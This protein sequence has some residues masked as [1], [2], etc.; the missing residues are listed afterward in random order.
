VNGSLAKAGA[1]RTI[2]A[3]DSATLGISATGD[4]YAWTSNP[5][6]FSSGIANPVVS[7]AATTTYYLEVING[8]CSSKDTVTV[9]VASPPIANAG[10]DQSICPGFNAIIGTFAVSGQ[11]YSWTSDPAGFIANS[12][13]PGVRPA[14]TTRY[15]LRVSNGSCA[16]YDTVVITVLPLPVAHA[17]NDT[18]ICTGSSVSIGSAAIAGNTYSWTS[19]PAG[20]ASNAATVVVNPAVPTYYYLAVNDG[21]CIAKDTIHVSLL[22][23]PTAVAGADTAICQGNNIIIGTTA[24]PGFKYAWTSSSGYTSPGAIIMVSPAVTTSYF[25]QVTVGNCSSKDT[26]V[27]QVNPLPVLTL[28]DTLKTI[29]AGTG[30]NIGIP[31]QAGYS[32]N[33]TSVPAGF[34]STVSDPFVSPTVTTTYHLAQTNIGTGCT[35]SGRVTVTVDTC[36]ARVTDYTLYPNPSPGYIIIKLDSITTDIITFEL[37]DGHGKILL[38]QRL[39]QVTRI[40]LARVPSGIYGYRIR[41]G[42]EV[43]RRSGRLIIQR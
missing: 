6:G 26:V 5:A 15:F 31:A 39:D 11:S 35:A 14:V 9:T 42:N 10:I 41:R 7:P 43:I 19:G 3:G 40:E 33:W 30:T 2:C 24:L 25:L 20:F 16:R 38:Q 18:T 21:S 27:V 37:I 23:Q 8:A 36:N 17:G 22:I 34:T 1:D 12:A 29:C 13:N 32:Y 4:T 28:T